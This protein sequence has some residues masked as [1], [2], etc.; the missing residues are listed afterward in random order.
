MTE[1]N[2]SPQNQKTPVLIA[3][4]DRPAVLMLED[5][6]ERIERFTLAL[7]RIDPALT[8]R[9]WHNA[10][11]IIEEAN[12]YLPAARLISLDHDLEPWPDEPCDPGD[13]VMVVKALTLHRQRCPVIIHSSNGARSDW[14]AGDF[15]LAGWNYRRVAP[16]GERWIEEYWRA[17]ARDLLS[18]ARIMAR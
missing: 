14:M 17:V 18:D 9:V 11:Q 15:E 1:L 7:K 16:I 3:E 12:V 8:L 13:G 5:D 4:I 6:P 10:L 2:G